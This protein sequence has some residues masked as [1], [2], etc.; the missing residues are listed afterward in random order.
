MEA[1]IAC[2]RCPRGSYG[3]LVISV[4]A[5]GHTLQT[6]ERFVTQRLSHEPGAVATNV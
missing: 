6:R 1:A 4:T 5:L 2:G 3:P